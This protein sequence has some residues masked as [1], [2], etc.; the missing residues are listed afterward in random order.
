MIVGFH[1]P[2]PPA[3]TGVAAY[4]AA[5]VQA[6]KDRVDLRMNPPDPCGVELYHLGN[7]LLHREIYERALERPGVVVL[8][9]AVLHH[10]FLG[11]GDERRYVDEFAYNYGE[12]GRELARRLWRERAR[13]ANDRR[14]FAWPML[15]RVVER[16]LAAVVHNPGAAEMVKAAVPGARVHEIPHLRMPVDPQAAV[17]SEALRRRYGIGPS[18][19]AFGVFGHLRESKRLTAILRVFRRL[20]RAGAGLWLLVAGRFVG[21][22]L[23]RAAAP[24]LA[25]PGVIR[26]PYLPESGF[27]RHAAL[28]DACINLRDPSAG[29]TSGI[30]IRLMALGKPLLVSAGPEVSRFPEE[31]CLRVDRGPAEEESLAALM[32]LLRQRPDL[33]R[34]AGA[35]A[36]HHIAVEHAPAHVADLYVAALTAARN[37]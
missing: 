8:H 29:E 2:L 12:W 4:S 27:A 10:F 32:L 5:L 16:S 30:A 7:N 13:S 11:F 21:P 22:D 23:E 36:A 33:A 3:R 14:Y 1:S 37:Q 6:M 19:F 15:R 9:D 17:S 35:A 25:A 24:L 20:R 18:D 26:V 28:V 31:A 34:A